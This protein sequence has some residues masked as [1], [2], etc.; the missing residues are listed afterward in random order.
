M[1]FR[2]L[3]IAGMLALQG[4]TVID[5]INNPYYLENRVLPVVETV[6]VASTEDAADDPAIW[7]NPDNPEAS[8]II[9]TDKQSGLYVYGLDGSERQYLKLGFTNN[10]DLRTA[11][12]GE[13]ELTLVATGRRHPSQL[14]LLALDHQSGELRLLSRNP[15]ELREPYGICMYLDET[16]C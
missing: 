3:L 13:S 6:P 15:V 4:C 14:L 8:L 12:W 9:G 11:P 1:T 16:G 2:W 5:H 7:I 10:V